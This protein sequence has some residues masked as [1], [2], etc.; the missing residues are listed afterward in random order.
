MGKAAYQDHILHFVVPLVSV[1]LKQAGEAFQEAFRVCSAPPGLVIIQHDRRQSIASGQIDPHV[2]GRFRCFSFFTK[3]LTGGFVSVNDITFQQQFMHPFVDRIKVFLRTIDVPVGH[4]FTRQCES[5]LEHR[6][7]LTIIRG[8]DE[9]FVVHDIGNRGRRCRTVC[10]QC[11]RGIR[12]HKCPI[13]VLFAFRTNGYF[14]YIFDPLHHSRGNAKFF[15]DLCVTDHRHFCITVF[16]DFLLIG[17]RDEYFLYRKVCIEIFT[18]GFRFPFAGMA[19]YFDP[20]R[21][22][23]GSFTCRGRSN[24]L[25]GGRSLFAGYAEKLTAEFLQCFFQV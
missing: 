1:T 3:Y 7:L 24:T 14:L 23:F 20:F 21:L 13:P 2:R 16:T 11:R 4:R 10:H 15:P 18:A 17:Q 9:G 22:F 6:C 19:F 25:T 5:Q 12:L 8:S